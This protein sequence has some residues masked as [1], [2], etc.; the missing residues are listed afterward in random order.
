MPLTKKCSVDD[1]FYV[2]SGPLPLSAEQGARPFLGR[3]MAKTYV[4]MGTKPRS[5]RSAAPGDLGPSPSS[6][7]TRGILRDTPPLVGVYYNV[8]PSGIT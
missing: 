5:L 7:G 3:S 4:S 1:L 8:L 2:I 6:A